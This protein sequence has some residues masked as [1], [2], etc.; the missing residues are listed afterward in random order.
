MVLLALQL[1]LARRWK[2]HYHMRGGWIDCSFSGVGINEDGNVATQNYIHQVVSGVS[3]TSWMIDVFCF[4]TQY[5]AW[6][7]EG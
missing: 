3:P 7:E 2:H 4:N 5:S 6:Q 1:P